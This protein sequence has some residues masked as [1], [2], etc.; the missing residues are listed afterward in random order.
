MYFSEPSCDL[1][2]LPQT[3]A[4]LGYDFVT[5]QAMQKWQV[6][7]CHF[8]GPGWLFPSSPLHCC[9]CSSDP[10]RNRF[11]FHLLSLSFKFFSFFFF[12]SSPSSVLSHKLSLCGSLKHVVKTILNPCLDTYVFILAIMLPDSPSRGM[13]LEIKLVSSTD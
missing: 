4:F 5:Q 3:Y 9:C 7:L 11:F 8:P 12:F 6:P 10:A 1:C 2:A 13:V